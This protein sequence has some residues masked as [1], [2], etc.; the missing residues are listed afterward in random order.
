MSSQL[1]LLQRPLRALPGTAYEAPMASNTEGTTLSLTLRSQKEPLQKEPNAWW[2]LCPWLPPKGA[3][4][5]AQLGKPPNKDAGSN[6]SPWTSASNEP[7]AG[8]SLGSSAAASVGTCQALSNA[9]L[10]QSVRQEKGSPLV[11]PGPE[12]T[13]G[14]DDKTPLLLQEKEIFYL[15]T[16]HQC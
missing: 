7:P 10:T 1:R 13:T 9:F 16:H 5:G 8:R 14:D 4:A 6:Q 15:T 12:V 11:T 3:V 2:A